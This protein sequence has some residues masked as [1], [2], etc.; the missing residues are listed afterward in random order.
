MILLPRNAAR[1]AAT[2]AFAL[3]AGCAQMNQPAPPPNPVAY[4]PPAGSGVAPSSRSQGRA[5]G[6]VQLQMRDLQP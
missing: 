3:L 2:A 1:I 4:N 5:C 6:V